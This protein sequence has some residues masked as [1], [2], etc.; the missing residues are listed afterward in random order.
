MK[1]KTGYVSHSQ[2]MMLRMQCSGS[3]VIKPL[4]MMATQVNFLRITGELL[5]RKFVKLCWTSSTQVSL[6]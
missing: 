6:N 1:I 3:G 4:D 5:V 2:K